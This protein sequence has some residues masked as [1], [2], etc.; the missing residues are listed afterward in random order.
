M[1]IHNLRHAL[2][3]FERYRFF[4]FDSVVGQEHRV[5]L[6]KHLHV[7]L[8]FLPVNIADLPLQV[9][10]RRADGIKVAKLNGTVDIFSNTQ[11][12]MQLSLNHRGKHHRHLATVSVFLACSG[13]AML[14]AATAD[15]DLGRHHTW[16]GMNLKFGVDL[17][18][19]LCNNSLAFGQAVPNQIVV[20]SP[21]SQN[22]LS[23]MVGGHVLPGNF[24]VHNGPRPCHKSSGHRDDQ[25]LVGLAGIDSQITQRLGLH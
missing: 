13:P 22:N 21:R 5:L 23:P 4:T 18:V 9:C 14:M 3:R 19:A 2:G 24:H 10:K 7:S 17:E 20:P 11:H 6:P 1:F 8:Q 12:G 15:A 16:L 25:W